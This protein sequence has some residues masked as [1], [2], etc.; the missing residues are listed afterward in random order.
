MSRIFIFLKFDFITPILKFY[1]KLTCDSYFWFFVLMLKFV[2]ESFVFSNF[3]KTKC[4]SSES[5]NQSTLL[6]I[7]LGI[8]SFVKWRSTRYTID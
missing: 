6:A 3:F 5:L 7:Q 8:K 2:A 4:S 1:A